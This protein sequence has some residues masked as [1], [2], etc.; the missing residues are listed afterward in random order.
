MKWLVHLAST[1][2]KERRG[3]GGREEKGGEGRE[4]MN[5]NPGPFHAVCDPSP[6]WRYPHLG[7]IFHL[8]FEAPSQAWPEDCLLGDSGSF[9]SR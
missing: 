6:E 2:S 7:Q 1:V 9:L 5:E 4:G 8:G 3:G